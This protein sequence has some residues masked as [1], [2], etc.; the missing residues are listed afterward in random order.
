[1][2]GMIDCHCH[3]LPQVDDGAADYKES[4]E[5]A[6]IAFGDGIH[7]IMATPHIS[8]DFLKPR[9]I[10]TRVEELNRY[11]TEHK[12]PVT[13]YPAAEIS[14]SSDL[15][16]FQ[17]YTINHTR[18]ILLELPHDHLPSFTAKLLSWFSGEGLKPIIAHPERNFGVIRNPAAF[19]N[20]LHP[21]IYVQITAGSLTGDF[22]IDAQ[23][24]AEL[25][26][27]S[28]KVDIIASDAHS[29][30]NRPPILSKALETAS[31]RIGRPTALRMVCANPAAVL[32]GEPKA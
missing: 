17:H 16:L 11:L 7:K 20:M 1:M 18:Y 14:I 32:S 27:D 31:K 3:I 19:I 8:D 30:H 21:E 2:C 6:R 23:I 15:S 28:G 5:M 9:D 24:C 10:E 4:I 13:I 12:I 25:L 22:G 29:K 26:L